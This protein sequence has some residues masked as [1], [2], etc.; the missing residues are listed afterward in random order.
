MCVRWTLLELFVG[1][2]PLSFYPPERCARAADVLTPQEREGP[3]LRVITV[4]PRRSHVEF[5]ARFP[6][7][8]LPHFDVLV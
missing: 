6:A 5:H 4:K 3:A 8:G 2:A 7:V 1:N